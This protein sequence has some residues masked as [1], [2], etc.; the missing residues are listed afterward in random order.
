[1]R[2]ASVRWWVGALVVGIAACGASHASSATRSPS[3]TR[4]SAPSSTSTSS[5]TTTTLVP[6]GLSLTHDEIGTYHLAPPA[7]AA[8]LGIA[9]QTGL[10]PVPVVAGIADAPDPHGLSAPEQTTALTDATQRVFDV[11]VAA[12]Q[13]AASGLMTPTAARAAGYVPAAPFSPGDGVHWIRWDYVT[14][15]F[16]PAHPSMLLFNSSSRH[17]RLIAFSY[18]TRSVG[19][20][21]AGFAG[22]ND[23]WH[24][25]RGLCIVAGRTTGEGREANVCGGVWLNGADL[26]TNPNRWGEFAPIDPTWCLKIP[27]CG[28][29]PLP[30][31][32]KP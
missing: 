5:T 31:G 14:A 23:V 6:A 29:N 13:R 19:A 8:L 7:A 2:P 26:W 21:P 11:Q 15:P 27:G 10:P 18:Y 12:A 32:A 1:M 25:H 30:P 16:D 22:P 17:A 20:P 4:A 24:Q 9:A 3:P 28:P